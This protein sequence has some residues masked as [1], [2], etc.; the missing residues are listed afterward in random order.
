MWTLA[1]VGSTTTFTVPY[2]ANGAGTATGQSMEMESD[3]TVN[4]TVQNNWNAM[5]GTYVGEA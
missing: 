3:V 5:A 2:A 4:F 1:V